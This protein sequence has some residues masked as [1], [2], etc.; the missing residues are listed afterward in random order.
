MRRLFFLMTM[1]ASL[2][3]ANDDLI[4]LLSPADIDQ[5]IKEIAGQINQEYAGKEL[6]IVML[7]KEFLS[8]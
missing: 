7:M 1:A 3:F 4:P 5:R 6:K 2:V 8:N